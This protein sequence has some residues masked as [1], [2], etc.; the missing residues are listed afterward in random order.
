M[1]CLCNSLGQAVFSS[2]EGCLDSLIG[3]QKLCI[4]LFLYF[5][6]I[7]YIFRLYSIVCA[8]DN[9][10]VVHVAY[11]VDFISAH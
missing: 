5:C 6:C 9:I 2:S 10:V 4:S 1:H 3:F 11:N 7:R 8:L